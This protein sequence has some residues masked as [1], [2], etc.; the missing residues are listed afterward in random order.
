MTLMA[1]RVAGPSFCSV[2]DY[3]WY[4][5]PALGRSGPA[6]GKAGL[7]GHYATTRRGD[8]WAGGNRCAPA[9]LRR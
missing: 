6:A 7:R 8:A 1:R 9:V 2:V 5:K 3:E 4:E